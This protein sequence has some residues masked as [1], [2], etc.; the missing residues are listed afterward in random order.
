[1]NRK[2]N[3]IFMVLPMLF[4]IPACHFFTLKPIPIDESFSPELANEMEY[5]EHL[6]NKPRASTGDGSRLVALIIG[7]MPWGKSL[8][9]LRK[10]LLEK[11]I[12]KE[13]W[14]I[15]EAAPLTTGKLAFM[16]CYAAEIRTSMIMQLTVPSERYALREAVFHDLMKPSSPYRYVSGSDL[17]DVL[18]T[19]EEYLKRKSSE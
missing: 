11:A 1:M 7:E 13:E 4:F 9:T 2:S 19:T 5:Y 18:A 3:G 15:S 6:I 14:E 10:T 8:E 17:L 16:I 12:I